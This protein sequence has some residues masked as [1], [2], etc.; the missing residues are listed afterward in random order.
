ML[1]AR[2]FTVFTDHRPL[3]LMLLG[4]KVTSVLHGSPSAGFHLSSSATNIVTHSG[5]CVTIAAPFDVFI[6]SM[7]LQ[8]PLVKL[9][10]TVLL[11]RFELI[12]SFTPNSIWNF[13]G[14]QKVTFPNSSTEIMCDLSTG[15]ARPYI[16][17]QH[18]QMF[19]L[20]CIIYPIWHTS[21]SAF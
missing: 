13:L 12:R 14:T 5:I 17:K 8:S 21:I 15:T 18:R 2:D 19:S 3:T 9:T 16:P 11:R 20:L 7:F 6:L 4:K 10:M 1:E